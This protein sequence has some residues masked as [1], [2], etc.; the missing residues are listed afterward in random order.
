[1]GWEDD[2]KGEN[3]SIDVF[4]FKNIV[5]LTTKK[6]PIL[7]EVSCGKP[8]FALEDRESYIELGVNIN[9]DFGLYA[10]GDSMVGAR[11]YNGDLVLCRKQPSVNNGEIA[12]I[13]IGDEATLKRVYYYPE[14]Q[15]LILQAENPKYEPLIYEAEEL[16][17][18]QILG[19]VV[20]AHIDIH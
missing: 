16:Q 3:K 1:M 13:I 19:K 10:H 14:K 18:I 8:I 17:N 11:I 2:S 20:G 6:I 7:G 12:V 9:A 15:K 4:Q 5:P